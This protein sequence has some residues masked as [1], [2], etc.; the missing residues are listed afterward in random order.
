MV[1]TN[2][3]VGRSGA[4]AFVQW[5]SRHPARRASASAWNISQAR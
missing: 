5:T 4:E 2:G 3:K 1:T